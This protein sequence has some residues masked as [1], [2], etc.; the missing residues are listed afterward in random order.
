MFS[1]VCSRLEKKGR[2]TLDPLFLSQTHTASSCCDWETW[3]D[4]REESYTQYYILC[5][6]TRLTSRLP[7]FLLPAP[8]THYYPI[9]F[10]F[11]S[12]VLLSNTKTQLMLFWVVQR[13]KDGRTRGLQKIRQMDINTVIESFAEAFVA[14]NSQTPITSSSTTTTTVG[15]SSS[16]SSPSST[17]S[18]SHAWCPV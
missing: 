6:E 2:T 14:A 16:T 1:T 12:L 10:S 13:R 17:S 4:A 3:A 11:Q 18:F 9:L 15:S 5:A 7:F 8:F